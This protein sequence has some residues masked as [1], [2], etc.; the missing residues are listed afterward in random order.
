MQTFFCL[1]K[2]SSMEKKSVTKPKERLRGRLPRKRTYASWLLVPP[3]I[4]VLGIEVTGSKRKG[5][6]FKTSPTA[7]VQNSMSLADWIEFGV[8]NPVSERLWLTCERR[9]AR[10]N[11]CHSQ[12]RLWREIV[13]FHILL[14]KNDDEFLFQLVFLKIQLKKSLPTLDEVSER[15]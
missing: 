8:V 12:A 11:V 6:V 2:Q 7:A 15:E 3:P 5:S 13:Y 9:W 14:R 10:R 1:V 4:V